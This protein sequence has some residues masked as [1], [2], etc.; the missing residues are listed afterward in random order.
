[1]ILLNRYYHRATKLNLKV[2]GVTVIVIKKN[3]IYQVIALIIKS[4]NLYSASRKYK[5]PLMYVWHGTEY[6][7][8]AHGLA[9]ILYMLLQVLY[10]YKLSFIFI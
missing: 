10:R 8:G 3:I 4:G 7:G 2:I 1:M 5:S 6:I 9:G